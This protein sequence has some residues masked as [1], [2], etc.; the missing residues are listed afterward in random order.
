MWNRRRPKKWLRAATPVFA[1]PQNIRNW[2]SLSRLPS[3]HHRTLSAA[4]S[5]IP[6]RTP[7]ISLSVLE[8]SVI[9]RRRGVYL[10]VS[11]PLD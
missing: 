7:E 9:D 2:Q 6:D 1:P 10:V 11:F 5:T 8:T 4:N 3:Q